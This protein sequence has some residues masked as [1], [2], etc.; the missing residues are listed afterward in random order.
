M[1]VLRWNCRGLGNPLTVRILRRLVRKKKPNVVFL[2]ETKLL[3]QSMEYVRVKLGFDGL[4]V[5]DC[6]GR[7]GGLALMWKSENN[8][9]VQNYSRRHINAIVKIGNNGK[10]WKLT[11][12]Y[13]NPEATNRSESWS[14]LRFLSSMAPEPWLCVGDFN[15]I[16]LLSEKSSSSYRSP[17]QMQAFKNALEDSHL[18]DLGYRGPRFTWCNGRYGEDFTRERLDRAVANGE[19]TNL[20]DVVEVHVLRRSKSDHHPLLVSFSNSRD[21]KWNK[22]RM[23]RYEACWGKH[24]ESHQLI[25]QVWRAKQPSINPWNNLQ[26]KLS[27]CKKSLKE[28]VRKNSDAVEDQIKRKEQELKLIQLHD[29]GVQMDEERQIME[30]LDS[31]LEQEELKWQQRAKVNWLQHGDRNSKYFHAAA[32]QKNRRSRI[33]EIQD[34]SGQRCTTKEAIEEAFVSYFQELFIG[35]TQLEVDQCIQALDKKV[36]D[37][38]NDNL[39]AEVTVEEISR[40]LH[41]MPPLKAPGP[42]GFSACFFQQNWALVHKEVCEAIIHFFNTGMLDSSI[43]ITHIA[44]IPKVANPYIVSEF[45]PISLCNVIY[46]VLSKVLANRLKTILPA[47]ISP[48]QSA[49]IPGRLITDNILAA[50]ETMHTMQTRMWSKEGYMGIKLD[51]SKAYD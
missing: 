22:C 39:V 45:R 23:F 20:F 33:L 32:T 46:K 7:S 34:I 12:F 29:N 42:D 16:V 24:K 38:M 43:N 6:H 48:T 5:V 10:E 3:S 9:Q 4:F 49:F 14:L 37:S 18:S 40:A 8:I 15:E 31:L 27:V 25:K 21:V 13:G 41:Q 50:Y 28:W 30:E 35:G 1:N 51:M 17:C 47:I 2:M 11:G 36:T 19:W 26:G 44:L